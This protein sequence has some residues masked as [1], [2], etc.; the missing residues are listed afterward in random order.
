MHT[1]AKRFRIDAAHFLPMV[2]A[3]HKCR[4]LHGHS[5]EVEISVRGEIDP[6]LGWL[7]DYG[8]LSRAV[9]A[10]LDPLDHALLNAVPGLENPTSERMAAWIWERLCPDLPCLCRVTIFETPTTR[11]EYDGPIQSGGVSG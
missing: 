10:V 8:D 7:M 6:E 1:L 2:P 4:R 5:F 11:C 9:H 3:G